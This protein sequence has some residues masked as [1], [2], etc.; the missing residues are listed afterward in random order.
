MRVSSLDPMSLNDVKEL[1]SALFVV[2]GQGD[3]AIRIYFE[4]TKNRD[5]FLNLETHGSGDF[6]GLKSSFDDMSEKPNTGSIN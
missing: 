4:S 2:E 1:E 3:N 5:D 6:S